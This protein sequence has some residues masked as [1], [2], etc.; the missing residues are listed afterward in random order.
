MDQQRPVICAEQLS[1]QFR[2]GI[3]A[4]YHRFSELLTQTAKG[5]LP[6]LWRRLKN[7]RRPA[8]SDEATHFWALRDVSFEICE[9]EF[10]G[11]I[12]PNG[13]GKSTLL[14]ILSRITAPTNGRVGVRGRVGSLLEVST[15]FHPELT[16]RENIYLNGAIL[17]MRRREIEQRFDEIVAFSELEKFLDT[18]V[19]QYSNGMYVRLGFAIAAHLNP[20]I[21]ILDEV[22]AVGDAMFQ[23]KCLK[24][25]QELRSTIKCILLVTHNT[26]P[27]RAA[28]TRAMLFTKGQLMASGPPADVVL[29][30]EKTLFEK[31]EQAE[32]A[33]TLRDPSRTVTIDRVE[34]FGESTVDPSRIETGKRLRIT[35]RYRAREAVRD[36]VIYLGFRHFDGFICAAS[37]TRLEG[38]TLD[39]LDGEGTVE[40]TVEQIQLVSG[41]Y[42]LDIAVF[43]RNYDYR[44]YFL[45]RK[46]VPIQIYSDTQNDDRYGVC[47]QAYA[48]RV[49]KGVKADN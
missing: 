44:R 24:R 21:L 23:A 10:V 4:P 33:E 2:L 19:K 49:E 7:G 20:E 6:A 18:P 22:L 9:G 42:N 17:G 29:A 28:C 32:S 36:P 35:F 39:A 46:E 3:H 38:V 11:I 37:S 8:D 30:Y 15:G 12:G 25:L 1:K 27:V 45:G 16:G 47:E 26:I 48:W 43:D 31:E 14:K 13:A 5:A 34:T 41:M 40:V